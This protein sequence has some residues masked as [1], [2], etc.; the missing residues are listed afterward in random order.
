[1]NTVVTP[2]AA[3]TALSTADQGWS[4][5]LALTL[6]PRGGRTCLTR[7]V[8]SGP[9]RVQRPF[10][11]EGEVS[12]I[13]TLHP[14]GG[15]VAG[16]R[17]TVAA[18]CSAGARALLTTPAAGRVYRT[19]R[20][21][22]PQT[23]DVELKID[24][25]ACCEWLPQENILFDGALAHNSVRVMLAPGAEYT[26][27]EITCLGRPAAGELFASGRLVQRC[28]IWRGDQPLLI[29]NSR[30]AGG[31]PQL[32][33]TWGLQGRTVLATLVSTQVSPEL[34]HKLRAV[35]DAQ[36]ENGQSGADHRQPLLAAVTALPEL[37]VVRAL[38]DSAA[39]VKA[40][41]IALWRELRLARWG[42]AAS[43]PRIWFT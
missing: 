29:E 11:P 38:A 28:E 23:Q 2:T 17:L 7:C 26:G 5:N 25:G 40:L 34:V 21:Q 39:E 37:L 16:D 31:S 27:W 3:A 18:Q 14:P 35:I 33:A 36:Q 10:Y 19:N 24:G 22:L 32:A 8:H 12:H 4:A 15:L 30:I 20:A 43:A 13:Y 1:M 9:L 6:A 41:F 42:M